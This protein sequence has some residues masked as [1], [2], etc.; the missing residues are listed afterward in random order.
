M[1]GMTPETRHAW[2]LSPAAWAYGVATRWR[3]ARFDQRAARATIAPIPIISIGNLTTG[4]TGKTPMT[5]E[6]V[7]RL[8]A[9]GRRPAVLTRGYRGT[10]EQPADEVIEMRWALEDVPI[11]VDADR[12]RGARTAASEYGVDCA[13][14]DDGFQ[15]RRL[16]RDLD[17]V[18]IDALD[19]WGGGRLLPAGRLRESPRGLSRAH[20]IIIT[21]SN[22]VSREVVR[23]VCA[24]AAAQ[25]P[26]KPILTAEVRA[27]G[28][29]TPDGGT[30]PLERLSGGAVCGVCAIGNPR[31]FTSTVESIGMRLTGMCTFPDHHAY[32]ASDIGRILKHAGESGA[33]HVV[34]TR[35]DWVKLR[36]LL[37]D[38]PSAALFRAIEMRCAISDEPGIMDPLLRQAVERPRT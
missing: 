9:L 23:R 18:L 7:R 12:V 14:L 26:H 28:L 24:E 2:L 15:H 37:L 4:G 19:P 27:T 20:A 1:A 38:H 10:V 13:V 11:V 16:A 35:K 8:Q 32:T 34:T 6:L 30:E 33:A 31:S 17:V 21:R 22:L 36:P 5:I 29:L 3:N 25:A